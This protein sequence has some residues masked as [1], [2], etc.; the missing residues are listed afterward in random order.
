MRKLAS[1]RL[2]QGV[3]PI[4]GKDRVELATVDGWTCMVSKADG[5]KH[6]DKCVFCEPDSVFPQTEQWEFL[7]KYNFRIKTQKFKDG[8][9]LPVYSQGLVLPLTTPQIAALKEINVGDDVTSLLGITQY[10]PPMDKER[11]VSNTTKRHYPKWLM[12]HA[13][14][15]K[16]V[17]P[18]KQ[19]V[20]FPSFISK[21]DEERIQNCPDILGQDLRWVATEK[22]DGQ[23]GTFVVLRRNSLFF[24]RYEFIVCSRNLRIPKPD[25]RSYWV[26]AEKYG[27]CKGL[28]QWLE[29]HKQYRWVALQGECIGPDVQGNK[30]KVR[31]Y[32]LFVFNFITPEGRR[33]SLTA[34]AEV[35]RMGMKFVPVLS[36]N[37]S[38]MGKTVNDVLNMA[39]GKSVLN[40]DALR[41]G[42]VFRE[43][44]AGRLSFK[45]VSPE[46]LYKNGE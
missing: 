18:R 23:S 10:E 27:I 44:K 33:D 9:G 39:N 20:D 25:G 6:G 16:L 3:E 5:F 13:W 32:D 41:E 34:K 21:T 36:E 37:E 31:E 30:Y 19:N 46:F 40:P 35:E 7:R 1:I 43:A 15:R 22:V 38:L 17:A 24:K 28:T 26:V 8:N 12:R 11:N 29:D 45:A 42:I 2:I 14:F 4:A